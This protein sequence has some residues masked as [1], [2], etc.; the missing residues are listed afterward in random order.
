MH[1]RFVCCLPFF[2]LLTTVPL[3]SQDAFANDAAPPLSAAHSYRY[4][5]PAE[6]DL[7][8]R[9]FAAADR[10]DWR[11]AQSLAA[12]GHDPV[13][14]KLISW[15]Y[16]TD[17]NSRAAFTEIDAFLKANPGWPM[18]DTLLARA[19]VAMADTMPPSAVIAWFGG[20]EPLSAQGR[21]KL[22][23]AELAAG[24]SDAG[25][26]HIRQGWI[27][28]R[29]DKNTESA[30]AR[31]FDGLIDPA[32][33]RARLDGLLWANDIKAAQRQA[34]RVD[35]ATARIAAVRLAIRAGRR[36]AKALL[37]AL[38]GELADDPTLLFDRAMMARKAN[39]GSEAYSLLART[40]LAEIARY[41]SNQVWVEVAAGARQAMSDGD[42][43]G[44][45]KLVA[46]AAAVM[47]RNAADYPDMQFLAGWIA[48][49]VQNEPK[50]ALT[51][52]RY[53][54][55]S[56]SRPISV[57]RGAYWQGRALEAL[58]DMPGAWAAYRVG[59]QHPE[60]FYGM[61]S[62]A[63][64]EVSPVLNLPETPARVPDAAAFEK[65]ELVQA[66]RILADLG[67]VGLLRRF[68]IYYESTVNDPG[69][70]K[71]LLQFLTEAGYRPIA[72]R[73][74]K[75]AGYDGVDFPSYA[76][77][78]IDVPAYRG[79][80]VGPEAA[81]VLSLIRQE[82]EFD[83]AAVSSSGARGLMQVIP[84]GAR[85]YA[86]VAGLPYREADLTRNPTYNMQ[87]GMAMFSGYLAR[88]DGSLILGVA[89]YNA[90]PTNALRWVRANGDPR[91][92]GADPVDWLERIPFGETRNYVQRVIENVQVYRALTGQKDLKILN[93]IYSGNTTPKPIPA[94]KG[95][96]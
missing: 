6:H 29:F 41:H 64:T 83:V 77:P 61:L 85:Q 9:A 69:R 50:T 18:R 1:F 82:T 21:I 70:T 58:G 76:F 60:T 87:L 78:V 53:F 88:W 22:G 80:G 30:L 79:T 40:S 38:P 75:A 95:R 56:V 89:A 63:R 73:V 11:T 31:R 3:Q 52:F 23:I 46:A 12:M 28:G 19:E 62:I 91:A 16:L 32:A 94:P 36:D 4:L 26:A 13:A 86:K 34:A 51:H 2:A 57:A 68:S 44:A 17:R 39:K 54:M 27:D 72:V 37:A 84:S 20:R 5:S 96:R 92:P 45:Y 81:L 93:D 43:R 74:A 49:R 90:G 25:R 47:P 67:S 42:G 24:K 48:L 7:F 65:D 66:V 55:S 15:R 8:T 71:R 35:G 59:A 14:A 10:G 33:E